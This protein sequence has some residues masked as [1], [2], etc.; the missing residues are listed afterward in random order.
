MA[1][2]FRNFA[3]DAKRAMTMLGINNL[4][5]VFV[6][7]VSS[8]FCR[9]GSPRETERERERESERENGLI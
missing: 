2:N 1:G 3:S 9:S 8:S 5:P 7:A 4:R 6:E